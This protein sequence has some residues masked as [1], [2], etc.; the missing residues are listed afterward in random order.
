MPADYN[1][2]DLF[3]KAYLDA[4]DSGFGLI[5]SDVTSVFAILIVLS[6]SAT[7]IFWMLDENQ[8]ITAALIRKT[9][10]IGFFAWLLA[11]WQGLTKTIVL[12]FAQLGLKAGG[13]GAG[14]GVDTF[15]SSPSDLIYMGMKLVTDMTIQIKELSGPVAF[16]ENIGIILMLAL[17]AV[18][19]VLSF[20]I[21]AV[22]VFVVIIEFR[23]VTLAA[24]VLIPFGIVRQTTF[25]SERALGYVA[26]SGLKVLT[27]VLIVSV[28]SKTFQTLTLSATPS[29]ESAISIFIAAAVLTMLS[30][31]V[32]SIAAALVTGGPQLGAG[33]ALAGT[34]GIAAAAGGAYLAGRAALGAP[35]AVANRAA[36]AQAAA[37]AATGQASGASLMQRAVAASDTYASEMQSGSAATNAWRPGGA[38]Y[39]AANTDSGGGGGAPSSA[40]SPATTVA[41]ARARAAGMTPVGGAQTAGA[42]AARQRGPGLHADLKDDDDA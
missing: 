22:Q 15:L 7:A 9:L 30:L 13:A 11:D 3:L 41:R 26:S 14:V 8:N 21:L 35:A 18:G 38:R 2:I 31:T 4:I 6:I 33:A 17:A 1:V 37:G 5:N 10:L 42:A 36:A 23:L 32:P 25:L 34:A 19:V 40:P 24:F 39:I 12:G 28:G 29:I 27:I 16:F 20:V